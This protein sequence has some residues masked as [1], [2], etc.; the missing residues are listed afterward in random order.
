VPNT[1]VDRFAGLA[2]APDVHRRRYCAH[3]RRWAAAMRALP[4]A[5]CGPVESPPWKRHRAL[6]GSTRTAQGRPCRF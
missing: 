6:P 1:H 5:V 2:S 3:L 4:S